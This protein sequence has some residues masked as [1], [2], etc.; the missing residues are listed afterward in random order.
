[1]KAAIVVLALTSAVLAQDIAVEA[2]TLYTSSAQGV[3]RNGV[4]LVHQGKIT[5]A[6]KGITIPAGYQRLQAKV[7]TPGLVDAHTTIGLSG[8]YNVPADQ[9]S[10]EATDP[11][12]PDLRA[13]DGFHADEE[14]I[15]YALENGV[16]TIQAAPGQKNVIAGQAALLK[17]HASQPTVE[18]MAIKD[19]SAMFFTL[20]EEPKSTY[21]ASNKAPTTRMATAALIR[22]EL[23]AAQAYD[24][25]R[26]SERPP[27]IDPKL[28]AL[29]RV[30]RREIPAVFT[31]HRE[32]DIL[33]AL[34]IGREF[35]LK[36]ILD[37]ATE[38]YLV[39]D[40]IR[41]AGVPVIVD[42]TMIRASSME[43]RNAT[44]ENAAI[45]AD[46]GIQIAIQS[47]FEGYVPK[48]RLALFEAG[49]AAANGLGLEKALR[50]VTI[51]AA[52]ILGVESRAGSIEEGKDADLVL[53]NGDPF[54]YTTRVDAVIAGGTLIRPKP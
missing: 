27:D 12:Q 25:K 33:T 48:T 46:K 42:P 50:A 23:L 24:K 22:R 26:S 38:G 31:A 17:T 49:V 52:R 39:A 7:V 9:D 30:V 10:D 1:M 35:Q 34:R 4:V 43:T 47:G 20:G 8:L 16:T 11:S 2:E 13:I 53:F 45:L 14:L 36:V 40:E 18:A 19:V 44:L 3:I 28:E 29:A 51:D 54:E 41:Q 32:D 15:R 37:G 5:A 21:G 6:G